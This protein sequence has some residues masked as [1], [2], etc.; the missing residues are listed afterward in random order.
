MR[1][2]MELSSYSEMKGCKCDCAKGKNWMGFV[3][4]LPAKQSHEMKRS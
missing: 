1:D 3:S 4:T 2:S